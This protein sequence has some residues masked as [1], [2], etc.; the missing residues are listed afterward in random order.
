[1]MRTP[2]SGTDRTLT[3]ANDVVALQNE[4]VVYVPNDNYRNPSREAKHQLDLLKDYF[5]HVGALAG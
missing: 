3:P 1:M 4:Q 2:Q 5:N